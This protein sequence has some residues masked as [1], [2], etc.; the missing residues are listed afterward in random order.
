MDRRKILA[1]CGFVLVLLLGVGIA[2]PTMAQDFKKDDSALTKEAKD[3]DASAKRVDNTRA[4]ERLAAEFSSVR[5]R[6]SASDTGRPLTS[7]D[8]QALRAKGLGYGEVA[9]VLSLYAHQ[10]GSTFYTLDQVAGLK[11][12][13][14]GW[15][16]VAKL[17]G[18]Q[19]L[20]AVVRDAKRSAKAVDALARSE[21]KTSKPDAP[22]KIE[23]AEEMEKVE[24]PG[25]IERPERPEKPGR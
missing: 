9:I 18:Y 14:Q 17:L 2:A 5:V 15:G 12:R 23:K 11:Q 6:S 24:K 19:S 22:K 4:A 13:G 3:I 25:K 8:V 1:R 21:A 16:R 10:S 20:G 7:A